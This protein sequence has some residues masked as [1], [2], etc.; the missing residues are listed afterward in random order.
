MLKS[1]E[2]RIRDPFILTDTKN[3]FY[4]MYGTTYIDANSQD[5][6]FD[7]YR[8]R[9]LE[10]WE[11]P[12]AAFRPEHDFWADLNFWAPEVYLYHEAY[13]MLASF[14]SHDPMVARGTQVLKAEYPEGPFLPVSSRPV[15]PFLLGMSGWN[16]FC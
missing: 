3:G 7:C 5:K 12:F 15:T 13:Y 1:E 14:K 10:Q 4:Y 8:S 9:N 2:I 11:G 16:P 6:G